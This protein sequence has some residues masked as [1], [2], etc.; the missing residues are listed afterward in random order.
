M[1]KGNNKKRAGAKAQKDTSAHA[2]GANKAEKAADVHPY[3]QRVELAYDVGNHAAVRALANAA[4]SEGLDER[5]LARVMETFEKTK[6]EPLVLAIA[7]GA[8][9]VAIVV[10]LATLG[11]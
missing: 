9:V 8:L 7:F 10:A 5:S 4:P 6:T 11:G 1:A 2:A 3:V